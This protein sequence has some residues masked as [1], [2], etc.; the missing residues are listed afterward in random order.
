MII[1]DI[2][3]PPKKN[4][5]VHIDLIQLILELN[6]SFSFQLNNKSLR[7]FF[8]WKGALFEYS[9]FKNYVRT[10]W[11]IGVMCCCVIVSVFLSIV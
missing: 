10:L 3:T 1:D 8:K 4:S 9:H 5:N 11:L 7:F 2:N 6:S